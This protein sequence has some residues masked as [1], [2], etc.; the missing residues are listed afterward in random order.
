MEWM[1]SREEQLDV[2][3]KRYAVCHKE[4]DDLNEKLIESEKYQGTVMSMLS[5]LV[6]EWDGIDSQ[7]ASHKEEITK[8]VAAMKLETVE[9]GKE[10]H[11][12]VD[13]VKDSLKEANYYYRQKE[14]NVGGICGMTQIDRNAGISTNGRVLNEPNS[15]IIQSN[16]S[17]ECFGFRESEY[18]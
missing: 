6:S 9:M 11:W 4:R 13:A 5:D 17:D 7:E 14:A 16:E 10:T 3:E 12:K 8:V 1:R 2:L 18:K 15:S